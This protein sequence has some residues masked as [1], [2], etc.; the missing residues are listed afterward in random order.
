MRLLLVHMVSSLSLG[1]SDDGEERRS[2]KQMMRITCIPE[3][4]VSFIYEASAVCMNHTQHPLVC[5]G[6]HYIEEDSGTCT[7]A[8]VPL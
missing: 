3:N 2:R 8:L 6:P 7:V 4:N 5:V 1:R